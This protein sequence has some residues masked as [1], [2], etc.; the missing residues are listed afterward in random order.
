MI[1]A[2]H[3]TRSIKKVKKKP[4]KKILLTQ[5]KTITIVNLTLSTMIFKNGW[6]YSRINSNLLQKKGSDALSSKIMPT[7]NT[8]ET[9]LGRS[10]FGKWSSVNCYWTSASIFLL[11]IYGNQV[12][13]NKNITKCRFGDDNQNLLGTLTILIQIPGYQITIK[14]VD[15]VSMGVPFLIGLDLLDKDQL[16][17]NKVDNV[18]RGLELN[19]KVI[20][21]S[22]IDPYIYNGKE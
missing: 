19:I 20:L 18:L 1:P 22:K 14:L 7:K 5:S 2:A 13:A 6:K 9:T 15:V 10:L 12:K 21:T 3:L 4:N 16:I 11:E 8:K 17:V